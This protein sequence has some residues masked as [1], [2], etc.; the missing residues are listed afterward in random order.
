[1]PAPLIDPC[2][3]CLPDSRKIAI[4][5]AAMSGLP[6]SDPCVDCLP[7]ST[8]LTLIAQAAIRGG[9][10][11][12]GTGSPIGVQTATGIAWYFDMTNPSAPTIWFKATPGTSSND[13]IILGNFS[14]S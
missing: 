14:N 6:T 1:M 4:I 2:I 12:S 7:D 3:D 13:W 8:K 5:A 10:A 11:F 9:F